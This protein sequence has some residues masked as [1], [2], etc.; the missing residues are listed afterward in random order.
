MQKAEDD[1][2]KKKPEGLSSILTEKNPE[3]EN[4]T[5]EES[6]TP[7]LIKPDP[8]SKNNKEESPKTEPSNIGDIT[9]TETTQK[10]PVKKGVR[11]KTEMSQKENDGER[12]SMNLEKSDN[13]FKLS[14]NIILV[15]NP[16]MSERSF[17]DIQFEKPSERGSE[18][19]GK[20][21]SS[22]NQ[23]SNRKVTKPHHK[24]GNRDILENTN[25]ELNKTDISE[26]RKSF[27]QT[28]KP[29]PIQRDS[30]DDEKVTRK[31]SVMKQ[32]D[33]LKDKENSKG[34]NQKLSG[35]LD[36][37]SNSTEYHSSL[38]QG[39]DLYKS[40]TNNEQPMREKK[41]SLKKMLTAVQKNIK[42]GKNRK[43]IEDDDD[44]ATEANMKPRFPTRPSKNETNYDK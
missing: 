7:S 19:K 42:G 38:K 34:K 15:Q 23:G 17:R 16:K 37:I 39:S 44:Y 6:E 21:N 2:E 32:V 14:G 31:K 18:R 27:R 13:S 30:T 10:L 25:S 26:T 11:Q 8:K 28:P 4:V 5:K 1:D 20:D 24:Y 3:L 22:N 33:L 29:Q 12:Q 43:T 36:Y 9:K 41:L 35:R 40:Q